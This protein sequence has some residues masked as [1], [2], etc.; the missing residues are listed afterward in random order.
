MP[1]PIRTEAVYDAPW[2][3]LPSALAAIREWAAD[4]SAQIGL[5]R[6]EQ[7]RPVS[8]SVAVI[9]VY[10]VIEHRSDWMMEMFGGVSIDGLRES[11]HAALTDSGVRAI[12]LDIDSPGGTVAGI[13][14]FAAEVR[15]ARG[16]TKPII[17]VANTLAASAAYW[18]AA[19]ADELVVTPSGSVGS[20]GVYAIHQEASRMLDEMGITT[21]I[22]SA[23]PHK[24]EGNEFEPLTDEA[25]SDI[26]ARVDGSYARFIAD[27]AAGRRTSVEAV[28]ADFGGGRVLDAEAALAAGMVDRVET[29]GQTIARMGTTIG[30]RRS[31]AAADA[32]PEVEDA[33]PFVER[34]ASLAVETE[35]VLAHARERARLRAKENRPALST[36]HQA[37]LRTTRDAIDALLALD[38]PAPPT[39]PDDPEPTVAPSTPPQAAPILPRI[40]DEEWAARLQ[41]FMA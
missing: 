40:S 18:L 15:A 31:I 30:R 14:E 36:T 2:A 37:W 21:T 6:Q 5:L 33:V 26:Q 34:L 35:G 20:V 4:P 9:P 8:G 1:R 17:A 32:S 13:T 3:I 41:E 23:G 24:T 10:G 29:L 7:P 16:G 38:E 19:Q 22:I 11:L 12:V 27:V 28:E 39:G 25:R